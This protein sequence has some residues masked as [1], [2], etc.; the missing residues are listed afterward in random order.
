MTSAPTH[1]YFNAKKPRLRP[2]TSTMNIRSWLIAVS[3]I[4]S[5]CIYCG[6]HSR[7]KA[8][9]FIGSKNVVIYGCGIP[10]M[11]MPLSLFRSKAPLKD[12]SPPITTKPSYLVQLQS[13][14]CFLNAFFLFKI[15]ASLSVEHSAA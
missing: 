13:F 3:L 12:P 9:R 2:M 4:L 8:Y 6:V 1:T 15:W 5:M 11:G 7:V 10:A 14:S